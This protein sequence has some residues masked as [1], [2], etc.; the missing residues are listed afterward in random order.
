MP[1]VT[2]YHAVKEIYQEAAER[3]IGL[4]LFC[5]EDRETLEAILA[6]ALK[7]SQ[8]IG[9]EDIPITPAW[10][11]RYPPRGQLGLVAACGGAVL[12][13]QLMFSDLKAFMGAD[14]PYRKLRVMP[15]LDH[16]FPWLD[17][18]ML[19]NFADQFASVMCDASEKPFEENIRMTAEYVEKVKGKVV[20]EGAV[21]EIYEAGGVEKNTPTTVEQAEKF[22]SRT[23]VDIL[24]PNVGTEHRATVKKV[25]YLSD[26]A[27]KI[28]GAVGKILCLHGTSSVKTEDLPKLPA[29]G[30]VKIN[31][32]T[33]LAVHGGQAVAHEVLN[34]L[35]NIFDQEQ[36]KKLVQ[37]GTLGEGVL[38]PEFGR[39]IA[40]IKPKLANVTNLPHRNAWFGAVRDR[41]CQFLEIFNYRFFKE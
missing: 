23:G 5:S 22:L 9:V 12:G 13:A 35:G 36:L 2:D 38:S 40:P 11:S 15:H 16:A 32:Y 34:N 4:P 26:Q 14:S 39:T 6:A 31:I 24:V 27:R 18:D 28:S 17:G 41:C 29:D 19:E 1:L 33:T 3:G 25:Q 21:D 30:F 37:N 7:I 8:D 20:V 10:T